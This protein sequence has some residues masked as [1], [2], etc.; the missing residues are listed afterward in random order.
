MIIFATKRLTYMDNHFIKLLLMTTLVVGFHL[1][2]ISCKDTDDDLKREEQRQQE[3]REKTSRYWDVVG[4]LVAAADITP[5][6]EDKTFEPTIGLPDETNPLTRIVAINDMG[7]AA[8]RFANIVGNDTINENTPSYT[9]TD[10]DIGTLTYTRGGT[11]DEWATV[12]IHIKQ[13]PKLQKII[14]RASREGENGSFRTRAYY[15]F[16]DMV[17]CLNADGLKEYWIC[18]RPA[19]GLEGK[20]DS[21]WVCLND[22]PDKNVYKYPNEIPS[23]FVPQLIGNDK[24][25]MQNLAEMLWA[26]IN[27]DTWWM[28]A[29]KYHTDGRL[30]GYSGMPIFE[31]FT[32]KR[33]DYHNQYFWQNVLQAWKNH[34]VAEHAFNLSFDELAANINEHGVNLLYKGHS[35]WS[36]LS[37]NCTL[38]EASYTNGSDKEEQNLHKASY[39]ERTNHIENIY[40]DCRV[41]G[42]AIGNYCEFFNDQK[43]RWT[44]RHATGRELASD[45]K[46]P[47][48]KQ[49]KGVVDEYRYYSHVNYCTNLDVA[50]EITPQPYSDVLEEPQPGCFIGLDEKFHTK[51]NDP[52]ALVVYVGEKGS[53]EQGTNYRGLAISLRNASGSSSGTVQWMKGSDYHV[54]TEAI[55]PL[56]KA[57]LV[58]CLNGIQMTKKLTADG[59][60]HPAAEQ[61]ANFTPK[62]GEGFSDWFLP[63]AGQWILMVKGLFGAQWEYGQFTIPGYGTDFDAAKMLDDILQKAD[64]YSHE[65]PDVNWMWTSTESNDRKVWMISFM[66]DGISFDNYNDKTQHYVV[67]PMVAF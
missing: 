13:I 61:C 18:V 55:D 40:I 39:N 36:G 60:N 2:I 16:G 50:P 19:F 59:H 43:L 38:F 6:Y 51:A 46:A 56:F 27:P 10:P 15:R 23:W 62:L 12:D 45:R 53:V 42:K 58:N 31:N 20:E 8:K 21:H 48:D 35:W 24:V 57:H 3:I 25:N 33:L 11:A 41:M 4:Q 1:S 17:S 26:I 9:F 49:L 7:T 47:V 54:C 64:I 67:I 28:N 66:N 29:L 63:S 37:W 30:W 44:V 65:I 52:V 32:L 22:L 34:H 14:F 5:D